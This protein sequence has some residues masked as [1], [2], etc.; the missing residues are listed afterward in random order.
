MK[1]LL[2]LVLL[3]AATLTGCLG[4]GPLLP[5]LPDKVVAVMIT[6]ETPE[7]AEGEVSKCL[8]VEP[9]KVIVVVNTAE[10]DT[11][12][13]EAAV[14]FELMRAAK[15]CSKESAEILARSKRSVPM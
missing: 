3:C 8:H 10:L 14:L 12:N 4:T 2:S 7:G 13:D 11:L 15:S 5:N 6:L 9:G 1:C